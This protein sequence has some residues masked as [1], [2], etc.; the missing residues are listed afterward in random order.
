VSRP[1]REFRRGLAERKAASKIELCLPSL[2]KSPP[3]G[4]GWLHE[5]KHDGFRMAVRCDPGGVRI[6][7]RNG[8]DWTRRFPLITSAAEAMGARAF[9]ID[10]EVVV[11][12][13]TGLAVFDKIRYR[14]HDASVFLYAGSICWN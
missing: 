14:R 4:P 13:D 1:L 8:Y 6:I 5:I 2:A 12:D 10:G 11:C 3:S 7:T 9:L